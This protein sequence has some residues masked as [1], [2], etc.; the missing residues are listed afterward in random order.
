M[1]FKALIKSSFFIRIKSSG[2]LLII[3]IMFMPSALRLEVIKAT[4]PFVLEASN[5]KCKLISVRFFSIKIY[6]LTDFL[7]Y[8]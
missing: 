4:I 1:T 3:S 7:I 5:G 6:K 2:A 8:Y